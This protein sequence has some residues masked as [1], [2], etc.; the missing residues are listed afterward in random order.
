MFELVK[1]FYTL[2]IHSSFD[3]SIGRRV[4]NVREDQGEAFFF[5]WLLTK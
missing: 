4:A 5:G 1:T 3:Y 2:F